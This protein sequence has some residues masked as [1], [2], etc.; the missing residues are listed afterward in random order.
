MVASI[1]IWTWWIIN[2]QKLGVLKKKFDAVSAEY[3]NRADDLLTSHKLKYQAKMVANVL[4]TRFEYGEAITNINN[5]LPAEITIDNFKI[6]G[7]NVFQLN[8]STLNGKNI[9]IVE[10]KI[11]EINNKKIKEF[12]KAE[13]L[14]I[15]NEGQDWKFS[16][17][18]TT[19]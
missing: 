18:V 5:L 17:E 1:G 8:Y 15:S 11:E 6:K 13:L 10:E 12:T 14:S 19:K 2:N 4:A 7:K 9:D 16:M 3:K